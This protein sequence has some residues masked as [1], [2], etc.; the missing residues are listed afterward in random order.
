MLLIWIQCKL[1]VNGKRD[2][3]LYVDKYDNVH[4]LT[5][6]RLQYTAVQILCNKILITNVV[7]R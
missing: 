5:Q 4:V 6:V 7:I 2:N 3:S 1:F